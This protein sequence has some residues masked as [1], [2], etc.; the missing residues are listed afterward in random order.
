MRLTIEADKKASLG[1]PM[2]YIKAAPA[3]SVYLQH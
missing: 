3:A 1:N 2:I